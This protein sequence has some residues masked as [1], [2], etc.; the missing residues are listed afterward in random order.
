MGVSHFSAISSTKSVLS[1]VATGGITL[2]AQEAIDV[3]ILIITATTA[4][5]D[6]VAFPTAI[7]GKVLIVANQ[8]AAQDVII[9]VTGQAGITIGEA[10]TAILVC[11]GT[12]FV[13]ITADCSN[14]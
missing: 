3:G 8:D 9:K 14:A 1:K 10:C 4:N 11:N 12:T 6:F 5:S 13:R 2:T 7:E